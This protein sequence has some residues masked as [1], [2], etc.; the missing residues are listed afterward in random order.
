VADNVRCERCNRKLKD[1]QSIQM[2]MGKTCYKKTQVYMEK[3]FISL[4]PEV[5]KA[6]G[7]K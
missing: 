2:G 4:F 7:K 1:R 5:K 6:N 3:F